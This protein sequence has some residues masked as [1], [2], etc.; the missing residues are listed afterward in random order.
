MSERLQ[1]LE[2][3]VSAVE[4]QQQAMFELAGKAFKERGRHHADEERVIYDCSLYER[5]ETDKPD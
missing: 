4:S 1:A 5:K 2:K 3:R